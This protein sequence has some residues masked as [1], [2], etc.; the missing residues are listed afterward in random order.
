MA[1][2]KKDQGIARQIVDKGGRRLTGRSTGEVARIVFNS[3][4]KTQLSKH[5][6]VE[7]GA[8]LKP[9]GLNKLALRDKKLH[10]I[11]QLGLDCFDCPKHHLAGGNVMRRRVDHKTRD[12]LANAPG[13]RVEQVQRLYL[14]VKELDPQG[15]FRVLGREYVNGVAT[16]P[17]HATGKFEVVTP[18]LHAHQ[19]GNKLALVHFVARTHGQHHGM[20]VGRVSNTVDA[21]DGRDDN[22]VAAF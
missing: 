7:P 19:L 17:K 18:V 16:H 21:R 11:V 4:A 15:E 13:E 14:V 22:S 20:V 2:I 12:L 9:L 5:F 8:L 1:F 6:K 3:F 10:P